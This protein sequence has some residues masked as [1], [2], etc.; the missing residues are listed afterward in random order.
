M[1]VFINTQIK[2]LSNNSQKM[3]NDSDSKLNQAEVKTVKN[4]LKYFTQ[5]NINYVNQMI[6]PKLKKI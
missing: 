4:V 5:P 6:K 1:T 3:N 2:R